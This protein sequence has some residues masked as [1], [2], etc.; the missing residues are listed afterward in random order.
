VVEKMK[1][2][3]TNKIALWQ[4]ITAILGIL[5][6]LSII[7]KGFIGCP[8]A[9]AAVALQEGNEQ[10][11]EETLEMPE[12]E[13]SLDIDALAQ[14]L[15]KKGSVMYGTEWCP[16]CKTQKN[17]FGSPFQYINYV[18]CD[19]YKDKCANAGVGGYP[20]W[21]INGENYPGVQ[22]L[23]RLASLSGCK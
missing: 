14:C 17:M 5:L 20:T 13:S 6:I 18:D 11:E 19:K 15:T 23:P 4:V 10:S 1:D 2:K 3:L 22:P 16:Y 21:V 8:A 9:G 7:T 12:T